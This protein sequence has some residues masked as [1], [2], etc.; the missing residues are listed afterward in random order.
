MIAA[1]TTTAIPTAKIAT[2]AHGE[3]AFATFQRR[4]L[5]LTSSNVSSIPVSAQSAAGLQHQ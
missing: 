5:F 2:M 1:A 4:A 3:L